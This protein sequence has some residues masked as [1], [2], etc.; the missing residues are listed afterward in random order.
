MREITRYRIALLFSQ[1]HYSVTHYYG[2]KLLL[3]KISVLGKIILFYYDYKKL[4]FI[5][6][7]LIAILITILL[8]I[9]AVVVARRDV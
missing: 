2:D 1:Y 4:M 8:P 6:M 7:I 9:I 3:Y 5:I